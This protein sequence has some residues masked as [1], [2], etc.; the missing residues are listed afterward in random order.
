M[1][2]R[3]TPNPLTGRIMS[4]R[5][6]SA[7]LAAVLLSATAL[8]ASAAPF[9]DRIASFPVTANLPV[10]TALVHRLVVDSVR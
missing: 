7:A 3:Q 1:T 2:D 8:C 4:H 6:V 5:L 10:E 9:F